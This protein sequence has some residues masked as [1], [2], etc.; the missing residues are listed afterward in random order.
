[1]SSKETIFDILLMNNLFT[2]AS[3]RFYLCK[4]NMATHIMECTRT[5][6]EDGTIKIPSSVPKDKDAEWISKAANIAVK[7]SPR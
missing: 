3:P 5:D 6:S 7:I 4:I 2:R 1:M